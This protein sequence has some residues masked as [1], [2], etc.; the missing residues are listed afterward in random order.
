M[1]FGQT[2]PALPARDVAHAARFYAEHLGFESVHAED[3]F[4][5]LRR[6]DAEV[7]LW[8]ASDESWRDRTPAEPIRSGA[9][10]FIAGTASC[11]IAVEGIAQLYEASNAAGIVHPNGHLSETD[12]GTREFG[13]LDPDGNLVTFFER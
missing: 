8:G 10:S 1:R 9:E 12:W 13:I 11:R 6:D 3:G 4:A 7:H 2:V 5:I